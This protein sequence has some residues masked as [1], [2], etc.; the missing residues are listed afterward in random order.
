MK[1]LEV[2]LITDDTEKLLIEVLRTNSRDAKANYED[3]TVLAPMHQRYVPQSLVQMF[4]RERFNLDVVP[5]RMVSALDQVKEWILNLNG[6]EYY[7]DGIKVVCA[8]YE[9][10]L[11]IGIQLMLKRIIDEKLNPI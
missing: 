5:V 1:K 2:K 4:L 3:V 11:E 7:H 10:C 6:R 8:D 9:T